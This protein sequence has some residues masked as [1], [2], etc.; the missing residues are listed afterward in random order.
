MTS[1]PSLTALRS[2]EARPGGVGARPL[3]VTTGTPVTAYCDPAGDKCDPDGD[4]CVV[5]RCG[6]AGCVPGDSC[7]GAGGGG[8]GTEGRSKARQGEDSAQ[9]ERMRVPSRR[10]DV[11]VSELPAA[12]SLLDTYTHLIF[13]STHCFYFGHPGSF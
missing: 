6:P 3:A 8:G 7:E 5:D 1:V 2:V 4:R 9:V 13:S 10:R 11:S 12:L